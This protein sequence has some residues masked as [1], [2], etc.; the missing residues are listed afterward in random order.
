MRREIRDCKTCGTT[1]VQK[2][3][4]TGLYCSHICANRGSARPVPLSDRF[5]P[6]VEKTD[7]CWNWVGSKNNKG[8]GW[9]RSNGKNVTAHRASW[10]LHYGEISP[11][12]QVLHRC[13][14]PACV[15]PD[16]LFLG[17]PAINAADKVSKGR[18]GAP[19]GE[20]HRSAKLTAH[21]ATEIRK[22]QRVA[23]IIAADYGVTKGTINNIRSGRKWK[24]L[25]AK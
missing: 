17:N 24:I 8:Y 14:N 10:E 22:D 2:P 15:R 3:Q 21:Q 4:T 25:D 23:R 9:I 12:D 7:V 18:A 11:G 20:D 5:W 6:K 16:H 1:F 13:D 19:R